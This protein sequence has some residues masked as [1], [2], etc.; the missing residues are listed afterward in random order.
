MTHNGRFWHTPLISFIIKN[1]IELTSDKVVIFVPHFQ[2]FPKNFFCCRQIHPRKTREKDAF[3]H[4]GMICAIENT[5]DGINVFYRFWS[6]PNEVSNALFLILM[7]S[8][9]GKI[10][11][12]LIDKIY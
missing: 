10:S 12:Y 6:I 7:E 2:V 1:L 8:S 3:G 4:C 5:L 11:K 9:N